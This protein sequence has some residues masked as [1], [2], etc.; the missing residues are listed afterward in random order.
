[1]KY[2]GKSETGGSVFAVNK[3]KRFASWN[4]AHAE[5]QKMADDTGQNV[6][7]RTVKEYGKTGYNVSFASSNDSDY[8]RAEIVKPGD[9]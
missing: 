9:K 8:S 1:M 6:A 3:S 7:I 2:I 5:A 4:E